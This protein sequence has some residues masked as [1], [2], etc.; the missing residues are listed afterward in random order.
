M[1]DPAS[2]PY[3]VWHLIFQL[4]CTDG[5]SSGCALARTSKSF[6]ALSAATR[7]HSLTLSSATQVKNFLVCLERIRRSERV[8][9]G[10]PSSSSKPA[11]EVLRE[12]SASA[13]IAAPAAIHNLLLSF[14]SD[15]CDAP[16]RTFRKW[17]DYARDERSLVFQLAH[18]HKAWAVAKTSWNRDFVLHVSR[19]LQLAA[20]T[21]RSLVVLQC[22]EIRLPLVHYRFPAL[23][24]L[25]LLGD[26]RLFVRVPGPG[27]LVAGQ[28]DPSDFV[29]YAVPTEPP[30]EP[31]FPVLTH[32]HVVFTGPK[33]HPWDQTLPRWTELAPAVT[34]LRV[35]QGN[36]RLP[37]V[38][39]TM[40]GVPPAVSVASPGETIPEVAQL[41]DEVE[42]TR[43]EPSYPSV[44]VL[45]V[46]MSG[47]RKN[48]EEVYAPI[49]ELERIRD[50]YACWDDP[51]ARFTIL[52]MRAYV[53]GYWEARLRWDWRE[54]MVGAGGCWTENEGD[55]DVWKVF[56]L[57]K[58]PGKGKKGKGGQ[59]TVN[60]NVQELLREGSS[61]TQDT[62]NTPARKWW[63]KLAVGLPRV[64]R[65]SIV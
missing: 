43:M 17:T 12:P 51:V 23:R 46:Q 55:E 27:A 15:T 35:S 8:A 9:T 62:H 7:F 48:N 36:S 30:K 4:V 65:R 39:G 6:R 64:R 54:R 44:R 13:A 19:L 21:L 53:P 3:D 5:G 41:S 34:H 22:P 58:P 2:V 16:Q 57:E 60:V 26:D 38:L 61:N 28:N 52:R 56:H 11:D 20:P 40:L 49:R 1:R 18:D 31:P 45:V 37:R 63:K 59:L 32:L 29:F 24:E 47:V 42:Q 25:T 14:L 50:E 10:A 33:L